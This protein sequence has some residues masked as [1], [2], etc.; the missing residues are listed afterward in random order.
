MII[1][2]RKIQFSTKFEITCLIIFIIVIVAQYFSPYAVQHFKMI[3]SVYYIVLSFVLVMLA[4]PTLANSVQIR[5]DKKDKFWGELS[6]MIYLSHWVLIRPYGLLTRDASF[7][8]HLV[9]FVL[10]LIF[11]LC[12]GLIVYWLVDR[13]MER[14]RHRWVNGQQ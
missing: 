8:L 6:F 10:Y 14:L 13:P 4:L 7:V 9:Y 2:Y 1:F 12:L 11:T 3:N 5:S